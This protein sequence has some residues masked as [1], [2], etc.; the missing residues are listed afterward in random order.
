MSLKAVMHCDGASRGNPGPASA[1]AQI[2]DASTGQI[3]AEVSEALGVA[4]NN[5]AEYMALVLGLQ[6]ARQMGVQEILIR[7]DS[8]L[9]IRQINGQYRVKHPDMQR[10]HAQASALLGQF[11]KWRAEHVPREANAEADRLANLA[12]DRGLKP[13]EPKRSL[14]QGA[15]F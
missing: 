12:L 4:T 14:T 11:A 8:Q 7:A 13:P 1:G 5:V 6:K 9:L 2:T 3:L 15:L 10:L